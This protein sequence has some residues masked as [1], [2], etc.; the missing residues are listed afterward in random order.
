MGEP[1]QA[2]DIHRVQIVGIVG[3]EDGP[4]VH[5]PGQVGGEAAAGGQQ[6]AQAEDLPAIIKPGLVLDVEIMALAGDAHVVI[7]VQA[8]LDGLAAAHGQHRGDAGDLRRLA[9]LA[10]K[11]AAHAPAFG[12]HLMHPPAQGVGHH[13]LHLGGVLGGGEEAQ[14]VVF[15]GDGAGDL[16]FQVEVLLAAQLDLAPQAVG[17]LRQGGRGVAAAHLDGGQ[18]PGFGLG[19]GG[20]G[21]DGGQRI[22]LHPG[23]ARGA[24]GSVMAVGGHGKQGLAVEKDLAGAQD[25]VVVLHRPAVVDARDVRGDDHVAHPRGRPHGGQVEHADAS[26][27]DAGQAQGGMQGAGGYGDVIHVGGPP[28]DVQVG[29]LVGQAG[30]NAGQGLGVGGVHRVSSRSARRTGTG[31]AAACV[32]CA[33]L[34]PQALQQPGGH[35]AAV[36]RRG[37]HVGEGGVFV[38]QHFRRGDSPWP[39]PRGG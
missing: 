39:D 22:H 31:A 14:G 17:G 5:R 7:P 26:V 35:P 36:G 3:V 20:G 28:G 21:E 1:A 9:L 27:G 19:G 23:Q 29:A 10:A 2:Q 32:T 18:H 38:G 37:A 11:A 33:A 8:Q 4:V 15:T 34:Q 12:D 13:V 24:A 30:A 16:A 25:G 6:Q